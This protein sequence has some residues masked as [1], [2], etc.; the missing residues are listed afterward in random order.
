MRK[1]NGRNCSAQVCAGARRQW[2]AAPH[3]EAILHGPGAYL[4]S[5]L[6]RY[7]RTMRVAE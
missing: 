1:K 2:C 6:N 3:R 4:F 5:V 7:E